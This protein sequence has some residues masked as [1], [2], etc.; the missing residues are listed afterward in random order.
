MDGE[1]D[2][3][4]HHPAHLRHVLGNPVRP[5]AGS[6]GKDVLARFWPKTG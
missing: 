5:G 3:L 1:N 4:K 2:G 6:R